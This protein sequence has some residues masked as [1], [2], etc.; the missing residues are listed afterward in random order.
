[1]E[2]I[3]K[4]MIV[5]INTTLEMLEAVTTLQVLQFHQVEQL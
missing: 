2:I 5:E 1:M 3:P 4:L